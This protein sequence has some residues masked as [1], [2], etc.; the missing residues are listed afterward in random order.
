MRAGGGFEMRGELDIIIKQEAELERW[1]KI[2]AQRSVQTI[3][4]S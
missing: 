3:T 2:K 1:S 4:R